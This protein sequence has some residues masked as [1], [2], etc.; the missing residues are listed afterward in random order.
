MQ[1]KEVERCDEKG[2]VTGILQ[3]KLEMCTLQTLELEEVNCGKRGQ[4]KRWHKP[5]LLVL[6]PVL[7]CSSDTGFTF[8]NHV[9]KVYGSIF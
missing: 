8:K 7:V 9:W 3:K 1:V 2:D 5:K 4:I 6:S